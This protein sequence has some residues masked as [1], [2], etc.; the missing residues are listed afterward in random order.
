MNLSKALRLFPLAFKRPIEFYD[1]LSN[2]FESR[3]THPSQCLP[4]YQTSEYDEVLRAIER[5]VGSCLDGFLKEPA[6]MEIETE[7]QRHV[8]QLA[9]RGQCET[10]YNADLALARLCYALCRATKPKIVVET[11]VCY[12]VTSAFV[13]KAL[14]TNGLGSL[15]SIDLPPMGITVGAL[16]PEVLRPRWELHIGLSRRL[17]PKLLRHLRRVDF[18]IH[19]SGHTYRN[20]R[21][22]FL[23]VSGFLAPGAVVLADDVEGNTAFQEWTTGRDLAFSACLK[24][25]EKE[26]LMGIAVLARNCDAMLG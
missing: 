26:A 1:R 22:E 10:R 19:D 23:D 6:L 14:E 25:S 24:E 13:L 15:H 20:M 21:R 3:L 4:A 5:C 7:V 9:C 18:F 17:L 16:V 2:H 8:G 11:G 12:G